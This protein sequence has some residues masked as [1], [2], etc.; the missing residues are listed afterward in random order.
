[1]PKDRWQWKTQWRSNAGSA[2]PL[3]LKVKRKDG[4]YRYLSYRCSS[5]LSGHIIA[6]M[7][8]VTDSTV[9]REE[10][11]IS[12]AKY[13]AVVQ[14]SH[15]MIVIYEP[16]SGKLMF[17]NPEVCK[18]LGYTEEELLG[19]QLWGYYNPDD[20]SNL[21]TKSRERVVS[22]TNVERYIAR[23]FTKSGKQRHLEI[24]GS[25][26]DLDGPAVLIS[27][28]DITERVEMEQSLRESEKRL[29]YL[30]EN[31][32]DGFT[33]YRLLLDEEGRP[34]D[35][36]YLE[37]NES[38]LNLIGHTGDSIIGKKVTEVL[39]RILEDT[40]DWIGLGGRV[41]QKGERIKFETYSQVLQ[42]WLSVTAF[43]T[44]PGYFAV[45]MSDITERKEAEANRHYLNTHDGLTGLYNRSYFESTL[46]TLDLANNY[47]LSIIIGDMN[48]L[49]LANDAF[50]HSKGDN[51]LQTMANILKQACA[52]DDIVCRWGGDEFAIILPATDTED[53]ARC[54]QQ[55]K[56][57]CD[58]TEYGPIK[59]SI[60]LGFATKKQLEITL[61]TLI[62]TAEDNMYRNK[63]LQS[64]SVRYEML[65]ALETTLYER[66]Q[67]THEHAERLAHY[68]SYFGQ[69]LKLSEAEKD[70]LLILARLHDIGKV[71]IPDY[72]LNKPG[73]L[74]DNE[75]EIIK[76]H[77]EIG[78]RIAQTSSELS[79]VADEILAHH[80]HW[81]GRGYPRGLRGDEIPLLAQI[82]A[83]LDAYDVMTH[84]RSYKEPLSHE[85]A[86]SEL[87]QCGGT[88]FNPLLVQQ[89][90]QF[91]Q[92]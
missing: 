26:L 69:S 21:Q 24:I 41:V 77:P 15:D 64:K 67:E 38:Y 33:S 51:L 29:R 79:A 85:Q 70:R 82:I 80:E 65:S 81:D 13:R 86:I 89:F 17:V 32:L 3:V 9:A 5:F 22:G 36:V 54:C 11:R 47:P 49:K 60:A 23:V 71:G 76:K 52:K 37:A 40:I 4:I 46:Q 34:I 72:I 63:L 18:V 73:P 28:H 6:L 66:T 58:V 83:I 75:W 68:C 20:I 74:D 35:Y 90:I 10:L 87:K 43:S 14:Y 39:P 57:L 25:V 7:V 50:G 91:V 2:D 44:A 84:A 1:D 42:K 19:T 12:E 8:D 56:A 45:T 78:F 88:Q 30:F 62:K 53:T 55:I 31:M 16:D 48:G 61:D 92:P 27:A 59:P